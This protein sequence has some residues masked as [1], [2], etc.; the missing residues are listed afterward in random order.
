M[1]EF[2][3]YLF[4]YYDIY[5]HDHNMV[6]N[7]I[8]TVDVFNKRKKR[9][10]F[11]LSGQVICFGLEIL[12]NFHLMVFNAVGAD[13]L[14]KEISFSL[15]VLQF[16]IQTLLQIS[17]SKEIRENFYFSFLK[18]LYVPF[19]SNWRVI[20][21][22]ILPLNVYYQS[23]FDFIVVFNSFVKSISVFYCTYCMLIWPS[24]FRHCYLILTWT[25]N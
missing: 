16:A 3:C 23:F 21:K 15:R 25:V 7:S 24:T 10:S 13:Y 6:R 22:N 1:N 8:I 12:F 19:F 18:R 9:N 14:S 2:F 4:I 20:W 11:A 17:L 5:K